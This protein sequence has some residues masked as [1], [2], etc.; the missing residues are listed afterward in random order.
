[1]NILS[2]EGMNTNNKT[3]E[4]KG[5]TLEMLENT[6]IKLK[7]DNQIKILEDET[8]SVVSSMKTFSRTIPPLVEQVG[9]ISQELELE[10]LETTL[11]NIDKNSKTLVKASKNIESNLDF[12]V[13]LLVESTN[14]Y[15]KQISAKTRQLREETDQILSKRKYFYNLLDTLLLVSFLLLIF[16][17]VLTVRSYRKEVNDFKSISI[18]SANSCISPIGGTNSK[19]LIACSLEI[20]PLL[21]IA[22]YSSSYIL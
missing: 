22:A 14:E 15:T 3:N 12:T 6:T 11:E 21:T 13:N 1:M 8:K 17:N 19:S 5:E 20:S 7:A 4:K 16:F 2:K 9:I 18:S 10:K